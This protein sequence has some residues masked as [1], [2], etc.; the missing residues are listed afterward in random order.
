MNWRV[1]AIAVVA[2][3]VSGCKGSAVVAGN[4]TSMLVVVAMLW[5][6]L[7]MNR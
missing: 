1:V 3:G 2:A 4:L 5:S 6:T 7:N